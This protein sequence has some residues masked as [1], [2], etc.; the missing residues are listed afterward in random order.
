MS[1]TAPVTNPH[2]AATTTTLSTTTVPPWQT[3]NFTT[4]YRLPPTFIPSAYR[5]RLQPHF[6]GVAKTLTGHV[7]ITFTAT[8]CNETWLLV[9][10][11]N[12]TITS[13]LVRNSAQETVAV[14]RHFPYDL[15]QLYAIEFMSAPSC[16]TGNPY[17]VD[18]N[19][20]GLLVGNGLQGLYKAVYYD[21]SVNLT[22]Y[23]LC[24]LYRD[25][26]Y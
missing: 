1:V 5:I 7:S 17:T 12:L 14:K 19:Y 16:T 3:V 22:R 6:E 21:P 26:D 15:R 25:D 2:P 10:Q 8:A 4:Y 18:M 9:N 23:S 24:A 11:R 20:T 13:V